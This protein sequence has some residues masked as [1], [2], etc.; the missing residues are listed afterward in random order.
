MVVGVGIWLM[1]LLVAFFLPSGIVYG[2]CGILLGII[3]IM[4]I[5]G[6]VLV[7]AGLRVRGR[8]GDQWDNVMVLPPSFGRPPSP[9]AQ[10]K[11]RIRASL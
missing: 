10:L 9:A 4:G 5:M 11:R 8:S 3:A 7:T 6:L 2:H 1:D